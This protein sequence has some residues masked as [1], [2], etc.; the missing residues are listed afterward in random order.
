M[1]CLGKKVCLFLFLFF[2][3]LLSVFNNLDVY[4]CILASGCNKV[5]NPN[6]SMES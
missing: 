4:A 3:N 5:W 2:F 6:V 1:I